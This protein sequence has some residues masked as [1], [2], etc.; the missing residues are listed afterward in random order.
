MTEKKNSAIESKETVVY[1]NLEDLLRKKIQQYLQDLLEEE[2]TEMLGRK[3]SER[4]A[5]VDGAEGYRNGYGK[6]RK[7]T[8]SI[9]TLE[10]RRPRVRDLEEKFESSILPLFIRRTR[11]VA[12]TLPELYLHGLAQGD[13]ELALRGLLG[14]GAALSESTIARLKEKWHSEY[15][16]WQQQSLQELECVYLWVDGIY[17]KAGL[18]KEKACLLVALAGLSDGRKVFVGLQTGHRES[19]NNWS[20][21]LRS[22]RE[23]GLRAPK[24]VIGDGH[25]GIWA[26]LRN[27]YPQSDE[28]RC[29]NHRILNLLDRIPKKEQGQARLQLRAIAYAPSRKE[30]EGLKTQFQAWCRKHSFHDVAVLID[31]DWDRMVAFYNYPKQHWRHLRTTN[32]I[33]SPFAVVRLRTDAAKRFKKAQNATTVIWK[34]LLIAQKKFHKLDA[35]E[36]LKD[37]FNGASFADGVRLKSDP[38]EVAA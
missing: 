26:A 30:A 21:L 1:E 9:G 7:L 13:F 2:L 33:E 32:P 6:S 15:E 29:W 34:M 36:L 12:E 17:V 20:D 23:R 35:P 4:R 8:T 25:L 27:V 14:D 11:E 10:V 18:E 22:L 24:L 16:A 28:Q 3:K 19:T 31:T 38:G 37:L 5:E